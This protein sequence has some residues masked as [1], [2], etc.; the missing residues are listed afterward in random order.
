MPH[1][2][3]AHSRITSPPE[4]IAIA[5]GAVARPVTFHIEQNVGVNH[6]TISVWHRRPSVVPQAAHQS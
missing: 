5:E 3:A 1:T 6:G 4:R 2:C